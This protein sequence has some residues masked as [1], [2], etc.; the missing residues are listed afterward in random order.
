MIITVRDRLSPLEQ[1]VGWLEQL[2]NAR[3]ILL[4]NDSAYPPLLRYLGASRHEVIRLGRNLGPRSAW[5]SGVAQRVGMTQPYVVTDPDV[6][7][8]E[9]CPLDVLSHLSTVLDRYPDVGRVGVGLRIDDLP[10]VN[11]RTEDIVSWESQFWEDEIEPGVYRAD[12]DTTFALYRAG[13]SVKGTGALRMGMPYVAR[14]LA[15]YEDPAEPSEEE[16]FYQ[17]R[18]D[19]SVNSWNR[20]EL[21]PYLQRLIDGRRNSHKT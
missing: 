4:D 3:I 15:W 17:E 11:P 21:P 10:P 20:E 12:V 13:R 19:P 5:L 7:P 1:L 16:R 18:A 2:D 9:E 6:V 14:H 8:V